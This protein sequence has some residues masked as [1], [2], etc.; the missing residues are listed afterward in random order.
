MAKL[1]LTEKEK[2]SASY[3]DWN[4]AALGKA[5]KKL[6]LEIGD[7]RGGGVNAVACTAC[8]TMLACMAA[9]KNVIKTVIELEGVIDGQKDVGNWSI[10]VS[11][12][13]KS[14]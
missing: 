5:V 12:G 9:E 6:A 1:I 7:S 11:R 13:K 2:T 10:V 8:A 3:L 4:D 14:K